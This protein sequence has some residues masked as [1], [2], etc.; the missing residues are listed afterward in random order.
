MNESARTGL[1]RELAA[2]DR[3][4]LALRLL[5]VGLLFQPIGQRGLRPIAVVVAGLGLLA[6]GAVHHPLPWLALTVL[7][8]ARIAFGWPTNDNHAYLLV[9]W[10]LAAALA[11]LSTERDRVLAWNGRVLV[12]LT[13]AFATLWKV[14]LSPDFLD[15]RFFAVTLVDDS[16]FESIARLAVGLGQEQLFALREI[17]RAHVDGLFVPWEDMARVPDRLHAVARAMTWSTVGIEAGVAL[18]FLAPGAWSRRLRDP[19]LLVFCAATYA[20]APVAGFGWILLSMGIAQLDPE[21]HRMRAAY[22]VVFAWI[23]FATRWPWLEALADCLA[24]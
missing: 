8:S 6:P 14:A 23:L 20:L 10:C 15:G 24:P 17:T 1:W 5:L 11:T 13:F 16:R 7:A 4:D 2:M 22:L 12:G 9:Y 3:G 19:L 21:W 18:T